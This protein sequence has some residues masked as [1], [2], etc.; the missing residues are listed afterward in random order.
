MLPPSIWHPRAASA[1]LPALRAGAACPSDMNIA[2]LAE[3]AEAQHHRPF[4]SLDLQPVGIADDAVVVGAVEWPEKYPLR[5]AGE[6]PDPVRIDA[7]RFQNGIALRP[8]VFELR[9]QG[10]AAPRQKPE[11]DSADDT[12]PYRASTN[13]LSGI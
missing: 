12:C 4:A 7:R 8:A 2:Q 10:R 3:A 5:R 11:G 9:R 6:T 1:A 13:N